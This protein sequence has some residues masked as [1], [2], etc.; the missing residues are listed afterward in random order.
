MKV[1]AAFGLLLALAVGLAA[2]ESTC[3]GVDNNL[4]VWDGDLTLLSTVPNGKLYVAGL[5]GNKVK[6]MHLYGSALEMGVAHG[7]LL[8]DDINA[9][10]PKFFQW[11]DAQIDQY[12]S[13]L[14]EF[15][16]K[17]I[18]V[19]GVKAAL[20]VTA[21][22]TRKYTPAHWFDE[23]KGVAQG[24]GVDEKLVLQLQMF[25]ELIKAQCSIYGAWGE[26]TAN[27]TGGLIQLRAL[28]WGVDSPLVQYPTFIVYHPTDGHAFSILSYPGFL[29]A[30]TG[31]S[32]FLGISEKV[33]LHYTG[34]AARDG[35][36]WHFLL[37]DI[38]QFDETIDDA[39]NRMVNTRRTCSIFVGVGSHLDGQLRIFQ[40]AH[41]TLQEFDD[42]NFPLYTEHPRFKGFVYVDKHTQP[43]HNPC[44]E[45]LVKD[46]YGAITPINTIHH[47]V[48]QLGTGDIHA[49][50]YD[51]ANNDVYVGIAGGSVPGVLDVPAGQILPA[52][53]RPWLRFNMTAQFLNS[54]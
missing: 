50:V 27:S 46:I 14:P 41:E 42:N 31:Y 7:Q 47:L 16:R 6:V 2:A 22:L 17:V 44:M 1:A 38:L 39:T 12:L 40:Y 26:A 9:M 29:G 19:N 10:F 34:K 30:L 51:Y 45:T 21:D 13:K 5:D 33:W 37:R 23:I 43:S 8:K 48:A 36:P 15:L 20:Q 35:Y 54:Q 32:E 11:I 49:A 4:P 25:P 53:N 18:E 3:D 52:Y 28:D 24:A